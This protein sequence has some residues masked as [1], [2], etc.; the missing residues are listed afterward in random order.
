MRRALTLFFVAVSLG[1]QSAQPT[2]DELSQLMDEI[3]AAIRREDWS[4]ASRLSMR[5]NGAL[6]MRTRSQRTPLLELQFL[7]RESW[8]ARRM[9]R[10]CESR[11]DAGFRR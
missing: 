10:A 8:Q 4:E 2:K 11:A 9:D 7:G 3:R 6:L 1:A 5:L